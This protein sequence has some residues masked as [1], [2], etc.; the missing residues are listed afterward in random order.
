[1]LQE[2][3]FSLH[4]YFSFQL[5]FHFGVFGDEKK[6][7]VQTLEGLSEKF[8]NNSLFIEVQSLEKLQ[9]GEFTKNLK[10]LKIPVLA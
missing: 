5:K 10:A 2:L 4:N 3:L 8:Q 9:G 1:L 6:T 7:L